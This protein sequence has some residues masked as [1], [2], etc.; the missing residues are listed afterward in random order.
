MRLA[1]NRLTEYTEELIRRQPR[2]PTDTLFLN[3]PKPETVVRVSRAY[4]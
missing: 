2:A 4:A 3:M 1:A